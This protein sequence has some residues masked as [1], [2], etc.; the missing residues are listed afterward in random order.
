MRI[1]LATCSELS[2]WKTDDQP[3]HLALDDL[4]VE[5]LQPSWDDKELDRR[6]VS[7]C[8]L[9]TTWDYHL[10]LPEILTWIHRVQQQT[11][12]FNPAAVIQW[13]T[14]KLYL[15]DLA[16]IGVPVIDTVWL[17]RG[18]TVNL[19]AILDERGW[20]Q[21][22]L[23]PLVGATA[24]GTCRFAN[25]GDSLAEAQHFVDGFL[26]REAMQLQPYFP[27]VETHGEE[28]MLFI[29]GE[30]TH[31]VRKIPA[32]GD[33]RVQ[34]NFGATDVRHSLA[35]EE[36]DLARSVLQQVHDNPAWVGAEH[37]GPLLYA[38]VDWLRDADGVLRLC[39]LEAVEPCLFL[40]HSEEAATLLVQ[41][42]LKRI[43]SADKPGAAATE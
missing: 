26:A 22:F 2:N 8:L 43:T 14:H 25:H 13:N 28:S 42:L 29:D 30:Y 6:S 11:K 32:P 34:E 27:R 15:R 10:R 17:E 3:L 36:I 38:R 1:A 16:A 31:S 21:G 12:L 37:R 33:Y 39:E 20:Q 4:G 9:R 18:A 5:L 19:G 24:Y 35:S 41:A 40:R 23:K 7:A